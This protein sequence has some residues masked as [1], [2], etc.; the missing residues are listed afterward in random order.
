MWELWK[1]W[2]VY[3]T[4]VRA[5]HHYHLLL[6]H[7]II[8]MWD[9]PNT[10]SS[11][12]TIHSPS[13]KIGSRGVCCVHRSQKLLLCYITVENTNSIHYGL[14]VS[15]CESFHHFKGLGDWHLSVQ[16]IRQCVTL[17]QCW[18]SYAFHRRSLEIIRLT[19]APAS[20]CCHSLSRELWWRKGY[21]LCCSD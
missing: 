9:G 11:R 10:H 8:Y 14:W 3:Y 5:T 4:R 6:R 19:F 17:T 12:H 18:P 16:L 1:F 13:D 20:I 15:V 2:F 21:F 7:M